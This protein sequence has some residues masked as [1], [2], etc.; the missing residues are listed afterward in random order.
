MRRHGDFPRRL[1]RGALMVMMMATFACCEVSAAQNASMPS[2]ITSYGSVSL[3]RIAQATRVYLAGLE[4]LYRIGLYVATSVDRAQMLSED[5]AKA[6]RIEITYERDLHRPPVVG[7]QREL[8]PRLEPAPARFDRAFAG[9]RRGDIVTIEYS[10]RHGTTVR[11]N[12]TIVVLSERHELMLAFL[13]HWLGQRPVSEEV[14]QALRG[15]SSLEEHQ[16][17]P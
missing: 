4:E 16:W 14:K 13:D 9:L 1:S 3:T 15:S 5:V 17:H 6:L 8:V 12:S 2:A 7:W 11:V 10:P